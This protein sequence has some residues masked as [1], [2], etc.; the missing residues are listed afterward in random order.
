M[1]RAKGQKKRV[2]AIGGG[3]GLSTILR[4]LKKADID[5]TAIVTVADD[6]GSSGILREEMKMPPPG[7]IRN[8][9]V[10]LAEREP[11]LQQIFQHRFKNGNHLAGHSLGN[12]IIAAM[13]EIT[14]DFVT[15]VKTLSRV[16]AVRGTVLPAANQSIRLR[17]EMADGTVV[18]GESNIPKAKKKI[19]RLSLIPEDI[20]ALPE[21]VEAV[22][23]ADLIVIGPGSL[24][25]SVLPNLLV[26]GI[27]EGIK[28]SQ[29]Q[30]IYI[31]NVMTQPGETDG[32]TVEDHISAIYEH[33][34][35][36]IFHK[37]VV[38]VGHIPPAVLKKY[39]QEQA[40]PVVYQPGSL[41]AFNIE[42][43]EDCL[44][45][46]NDYLRHDAQKVTEIVLR[47]LHGSS[48]KR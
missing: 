11:L 8:V 23:Q 46:V 5:L 39:E 14:G 19:A 42:V 22:E 37:V 12:L 33:I 7:D 44:F 45:M 35:Q 1:N 3:T 9:L 32:Y 4:G 41:D 29:A 28:N 16:F 15:A 2:V 20:E 34:G 31:C 30:V 43:I 26:P 25:T 13:Q 21:A 38:N 36:P 6:G 40:Y 48:R 24:Y 47:C 10:A 18:I 27:Q 17:A